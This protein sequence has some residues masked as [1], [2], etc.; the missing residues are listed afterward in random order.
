MEEK[1]RIWLLFARKLTGEATREELDELQEL[2]QKYPDITFPVQFLSDAWKQKNE[3]EDPEAEDAYSRHLRRLVQQKSSAHPQLETVSTS[4]GQTASKQDSWPGSQEKKGLYSSWEGSKAA[5]RNYLKVTKQNLVRNKLF[6][7][8]NITGLA[9]G[10]ASA[11]L[12]WLWI[13]HEITFDQFHAKK[14]RIYKVGINAQVDGSIDT[15]AE[16]PMVLGPTLK[17]D[18]P[19]EIEEF[20]RDNW[21]AAFILHSNGQ[22]I[23]TEGDIVDPSFLK[24]FSFPL[25]R[26]NPNTAL[27][28]IHSILLTESLAKQMFGNDDPMGK[29]IR[30]DSNAYFTVRGILK[31]LPYNTGFRFKYLVPWSYMK[32]V[33][34]E[35]LQWNEHT[36]VSTFLLLK[37]G[38]T[39]KQCDDLMANEIKKYA[40]S[41][42]YEVFLHPLPRLRLWSRYE[43][44]VN[45]GGYITTVKL[46]GLIGAFILL[47]ACI[48]Y[49]NLSTARS[50]KRATEVGLR[51][52]MGAQKG[53]LVG[54]FMVESILVSLLAGGIALC[55]VQP[56]LIWFNWLTNKALFVPWTDINFWLCGLGFMI[57]TGIIAGSY[58]AFYL[59]AYK[60]IVVLRGTFKAVHALV[61]P[62]KVLVVLQFTFAIGFII[63]T[64]VIYRQIAYGR[65]QD[66]GYD[67]SNLVFV[68]IKGN[69]NKEY[70]KIRQDMMSS[71]AVTS[72]TRTNSPI[73]YV[74]NTE[75]R[76]EWP[77]KDSSTHVLFNRM[78]TESDF[79]KTMGLTLVAGRDIDVTKYPADSLAL[80]LNESAARVIGMKDPIGKEITNEQGTWKIVGV[81]KNIITG[82]P[83]SPV[84]P[85]LV[86]GPGRPRN[87]YGTITFRLNAEHSRKA[88]LKV[89]EN[90][91]KKYNPD[92]P[93]AS[94]TVEDA[95][96]QQF[97]YEA[98]TGTLAAVFAGFTIFIACLGLFAL[99]AYMA[100]SRTKEIGI[101]KVLG[102][103]VTGIV[104]LL[105]KD[106]LKLVIVSFVIASPI[107][108]WMM[109][110]WLKD[111]QYHIGIGW[112][113]FML[114][115]VI[116]IFVAIGTVSY[117][118][119]KAAM[120]KPVESLRSE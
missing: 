7:F 26:G 18:F 69:V 112:W 45:T 90:I 97:D 47:I 40:K 13:Q 98:R 71:G 33:G 84:Y 78:N 101:R 27:D 31:D 28:T 4:G 55:I 94:Y 36:I 25:L 62:R 35:N 88:N 48:N 14:D 59:A 113:I 85:M 72:V 68:Y 30:V 76:Y 38:V 6:S 39:K 12:I 86:Q 57:F 103:S 32:E 16:T 58:P 95:Y 34:W 91:F 111:F 89:I 3:K 53:S 80:L 17:A 67:M 22:H 42:P 20:S 23:Q 119:I 50:V 117:Q 29:T 81:F 8:I 102:A 56:S 5:L 52:V 107:A 21:V 65:N 77:G 120:M 2:L 44:G 82:S 118:A 37:P 92:Y 49:M 110:G 73:N 114:A 83:Y 115:G 109:K 43:N 99:A 19:N 46:F 41:L 11:I 75:D 15:W 116:T 74:W 87:W 70:P 10:M 61:T 108:W 60:P 63:C 105:S 93:F 96:F 1:D 24:I 66:T 106:F 9:I 79:V 100:E 51:K 54:Q 64:I 104:A